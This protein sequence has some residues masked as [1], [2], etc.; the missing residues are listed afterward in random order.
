MLRY[1]NSTIT[2]LLLPQCRVVYADTVKN[3]EY[4]KEVRGTACDHYLVCYVIDVLRLEHKSNLANLAEG[5]PKD[6]L[7]EFANDIDWHTLARRVI[8]E[9]EDQDG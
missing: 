8:N 2:T 5:L 1:Y 4:Y 9:Y 3:D 6:L 7:L